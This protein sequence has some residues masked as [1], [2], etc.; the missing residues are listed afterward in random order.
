MKIKM[1]NVPLSFALQTDKPRHKA[2]KKPNILFRT[3]V[4]LLSI[5]DMLN[6]RFSYTLD[7]NL[8]IGKEPYF[9][10]MNHSSFIDLKIAF[11]ILYPKPFNIVAT[12]DAFVGKGWLMRNLGCIATQKFVTDVTL[13][14]DIITAVKKNKTSVL[15]YPE[16]GYTLD[17][18]ATKLPRG[19]GK[20][21]KKLDVPVLSIITDG[22][23][24][25]EPLYNGLQSRKIK[26]SAH[27]KCLLTLQEVRSKTIEEIDEILDKEYSFDSFKNQ[28]ENKIHITEKFR[29]DGLHRILYKCPECLAEGEMEGKGEKIRCNKCGKIYYMDTLGRLGAVNGKT[30]FS[31][32]TDWYDWQRSCVKE[33][34][35]NSDYNSEMQVDI[36]IIR[37]Y[38]AL[39]MVG[40]GTLIQNQNGFTLKG[41]DGKLNYSQSH[42]TSYSLNAD[43][44]WYQIGDVI[45]IGDKE[46]LYY[47]FIK[48]GSSV[49][50]A[51]LAAEEIY[52]TMVEE[53]NFKV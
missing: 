27:V 52:I 13:V 5:P 16:A 36:G 33:E 49:T 26:V 43:Y 21:F 12:T 37:D 10:L 42:K 25:R 40:S 15:M 41:C 47:C 18:R 30:Q 20:L 45:G 28:Y 51:R 32:I 53:G 19:M 24:L 17:G 11:K 1:K 50:K 34:I 31:D 8:K 44:F 2:P 39:Y 3:L 48:D 9:I 22:A 29:A 14:K 7:E 35:K 4:R 6:T 23:F 38:K 46:A